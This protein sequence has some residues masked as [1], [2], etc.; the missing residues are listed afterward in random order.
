MRDVQVCDDPSVV[1][2]SP[3]RCRA[4]RALLNWS[5]AYLARLVTKEAGVPLIAAD[6]TE[7]EDFGLMMDCMSTDAVLTLLLQKV[8]FTTAEGQPGVVRKPDV[9]A[10][11]GAGYVQFGGLRRRRGP[12]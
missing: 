3:E 6:I 2:L 8:E 1:W 12:L 11:Q 5:P 4:A 10:T 9:G 7:F